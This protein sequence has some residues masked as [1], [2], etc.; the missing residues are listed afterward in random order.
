MSNEQ[1][2]EIEEHEGLHFLRLLGLEHLAE[3]E[4]HGPNGTFLAKDFLEV[5]GQHAKPVLVGFEDMSP[6]DPEYETTKNSLSQYIGQIL[7]ANPHA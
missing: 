1:L 4:V 6:D 7:E 3:R 5:C 2:G